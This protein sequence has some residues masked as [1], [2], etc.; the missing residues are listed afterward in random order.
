MSIEPPLGGV[1]VIDTASTSQP[2]LWPSVAALLISGWLGGIVA[3]IL[4]APLLGVMR[5]GNVFA[6]GVVTA[7]WLAPTLAG[8]LVASAL[9]P[10]FLRAFCEFELGLGSAFVVTLGRSLAG[11]AASTFL[12]VSLH[13]AV[14]P[15]SATLFLLPEIVSL[16]VGYQLLKRLAQPVPKLARGDLVAQRWLEQQEPGPAHAA[17]GEWDGLLAAVRIEVAQTISLLEQAEHTAVPAAVA[18][19][20][21][22]LE[23]LA[24]RIEEAPPPSAAGHAAQLDLVAGIR[25]LQGDLVDLAETAW[26]GDHR[27]EV[28]HLRGLD[29]IH[30]ALARLD[31]VR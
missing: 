5:F 8:A 12:P 18:E 20:L 17:S 13:G 3:T 7:T 6:P 27:R 10:R 24:D 28:E 19:A 15:T 29:E 11:F 16:V 21:P 23:A 9:L 26:R 31:S 2:P 30:R 1:A 22:G 25:R 14:M 4:W